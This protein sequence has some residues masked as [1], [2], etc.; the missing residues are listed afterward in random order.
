M[1][2]LST[3]NFTILSHKIPASL[4]VYVCLTFQNNEKKNNESKIKSNISLGMLYF[5]CKSKIHTM[6]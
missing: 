5:H 6:S 2:N 4:A 3:P 1:G